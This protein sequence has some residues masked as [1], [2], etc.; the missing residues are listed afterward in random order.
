M[1]LAAC[2]MDT[3]LIYRGDTPVDV[4][5]SRPHIATALRAV[6]PAGAASLAFWHR[7][8]GQVSI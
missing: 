5:P 4:R 3:Y 6:V 2:D 7:R 1:I 8:L